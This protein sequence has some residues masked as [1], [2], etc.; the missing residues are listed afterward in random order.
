MRNISIEILQANNTV[1]TTVSN[2]TTTN[3]HM[4]TAVVNLEHVLLDWKTAKPK[5]KKKRCRSTVQKW[6]NEFGT[7]I[8]SD[9]R[10]F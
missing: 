4:I 7:K 6:P 8:D 5:T 10:Y 3:A 2:Y 9:E 1:S